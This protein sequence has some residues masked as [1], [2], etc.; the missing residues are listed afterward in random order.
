MDTEEL[1][2]LIYEVHER[3]LGITPERRLDSE[4]KIGFMKI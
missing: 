2:E 4:S 3:V 1:D